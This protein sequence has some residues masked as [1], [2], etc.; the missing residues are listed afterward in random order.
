M[1]DLLLAVQAK[2]RSAITAVRDRDVVILENEDLL[3]ESI[4]YP[5]VGIKDGPAA[6]T[7][8][9][10]RSYD[11]EP[12]VRITVYV[13]LGRPAESVMDPDT[14]VLALAA[15]ARDAL[16]NDTLGV[17]GV[18]QVHPGPEEESRTFS[19]GKELIQKKT[20]SMIYRRTVNL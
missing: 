4:G 8:E 16:T 17:P 9:T 11:V 19:D 6:W 3:P 1:R 7:P 10:S 18:Y 14:G 12:R 20:V 2:L 5:A 15:A 13:R